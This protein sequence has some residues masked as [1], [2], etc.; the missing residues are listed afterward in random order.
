VTEQGTTA[1]NKDVSPSKSE[2]SSEQ[3]TPR[4]DWADPNVP[5]GNAP[6]LPKWPL[7]LSICAWLVWV[8]FL[9]VMMLA[10]GHAGATG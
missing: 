7:A 1:D 9:V 6:P 5:V 8:V 3:A 10:D 2:P 4:I